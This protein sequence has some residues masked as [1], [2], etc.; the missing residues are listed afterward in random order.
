MSNIS[1]GNWKA[2]VLLVPPLLHFTSSGSVDD[3]EPPSSVRSVPIES[4]GL[5]N[6]IR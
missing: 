4:Q 5:V 2:L 3:G 6:I 1:E